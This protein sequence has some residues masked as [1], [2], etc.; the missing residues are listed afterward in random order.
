MLLFCQI[1]IPAESSHGNAFTFSVGIHYIGAVKVIG[2]LKIDAA[3]SAQALNGHRNQQM[4][5]IHHCINVTYLGSS[6][7][8]C[9]AVKLVVGRRD[10]KLVAL[11]TLTLKVVN[12]NI[13]VGKELM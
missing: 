12:S 13:D 6:A 1:I 7:I 2:N 8:T 3:S 5:T 10:Y 4:L 9:K 11:P